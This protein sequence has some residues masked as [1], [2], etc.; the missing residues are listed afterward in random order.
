MSW[1]L[2][3]QL[4][5]DTIL[6]QET[7]EDVL[8]LMNQR[9]FPWVILVP[10]VEGAREL[11][12]LPTRAQASLWGR[13][14]DVSE[15][16]KDTLTPTKLNVATLG[17]VVEQLHVH[18]IARYAGDAMWPKPVWGHEIKPYSAKEIEEIK[19]MWS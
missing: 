13:I 9:E 3:P 11:I 15:Y 10:K 4:Q 5:A 18:I 17:N 12:D 8:L 2:H 14:L 1:Q 16:M 6:L 7:E 19:A